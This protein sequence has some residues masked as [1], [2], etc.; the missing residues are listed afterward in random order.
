MSNCSD[1]LVILIA[2]EKKLVM[3]SKSQPQLAEF[4]TLG[5]AQAACWSQLF[6]LRETVLLVCFRLQPRPS[7]RE[8][9]SAVE[10]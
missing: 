8:S 7:K 2:V 4:L 10:S 5:V 1:T 6:S 9:C 3:C